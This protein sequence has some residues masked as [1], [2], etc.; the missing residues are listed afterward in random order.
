[1]AA[2]VIQGRLQGI[3][4]DDRGSLYVAEYD[5]STISNVTSAGMVS[6]IAGVAGQAS[7]EPGP[8]PG[9]LYHPIGLALSASNLFV[10]LGDGVAVVRNRP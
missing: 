5:N 7:F 4:V 9:K 10:T 1:M 6:T 8:L 3:A 2:G